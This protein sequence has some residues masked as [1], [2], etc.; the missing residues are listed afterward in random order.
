MT[1]SHC[2]VVLY[3]GVRH[4]LYAVA[5]C[6]HGT[7]TLSAYIYRHVCFFNVTFNSHVSTEHKLSCSSWYCCSIRVEN[8]L[9]KFSVIV[10]L[11]CRSFTFF[12][13]LNLRL[14]WNDA[15]QLCV[16]WQVTMHDP[17]W[18]VT[19]CICEDLGWSLINCYLLLTYI[20]SKY[21][22]HVEI[23]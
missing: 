15:I 8:T 9:Q 2:A 19:A 21:C 11:S 14:L 16:R 12:I 17:F 18:Q 5:W 6:C 1:I 22:Q 4:L 20:G 3:L 7:Q 13:F 23:F 10:V